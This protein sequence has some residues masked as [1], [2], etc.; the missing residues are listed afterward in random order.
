MPVALVVAVSI[1]AGSWMFFRMRP[2]S[3]RLAG[4]SGC[5]GETT[6]GTREYS[7]DALRQVRYT[8]RR[9]RIYQGL[10][11]G[12]DAH[13]MTTD[14]PEEPSSH[15][16]FVYFLRVAEGGLDPKQSFPLATLSE[17]ADALP[18]LEIVLILGGYVSDELGERARS[19]LTST[20][21]VRI[22]RD[23]T[24]FSEAHIHRDTSGFGFL[25][26][27][28]GAVLVRRPGLRTSNVTPSFDALQT[29]VR[30]GVLPDPIYAFSMTHPS[31]VTQ[32]PL[33]LGTAYAVEQAEA[34]D[35]PT[36]G[37]PTL[38][39]RFSP[40]CPPCALC[41]EVTSSLAAEYNGRANVVGLAYLLS[42]AILASAVEVGHAH[43]AMLSEDKKAAILELPTSVEGQRDVHAQQVAEVSEYMET[44][45]TRFPV[46]IDEDARYA[47]ALGMGGAP[48]PA[49]GLFDADGELMDILP[50]A[51]DTVYEDGEPL[52]I[53]YPTLA[54]LRVRLDELLDVSE[55][56]PA[57]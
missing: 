57:S 51:Q 46:V 52:S 11:E 32:H 25:L 55:G 26:G 41:T 2:P 39:Y 45:R 48:L 27:E 23:G 21:T 54:M 19:A 43:L 28:D 6:A 56:N 44:L 36:L 42:Q 34:L 50:A 20:I 15:G 40:G 10:V 49:W 4:C 35:A 31:Q 16:A 24:L 33:A 38:V 37:R 12:S 7:I 5:A 8:T 53:C 3:P 9:D 17:W 14:V 1:G 18:G 29:Y 22:D 47:G 30:E 13:W